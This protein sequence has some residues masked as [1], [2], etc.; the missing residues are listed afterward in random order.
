MVENMSG[1]VCPD[2]GKTYDIFGRGGA[3]AKA[4]ELDVSVSWANCRSTSRLRTAGDEGRLA[5][6]IDNDQR[7]RAPLEAVT[8][9]A[10]SDTRGPQAAASPPKAE[11]A[12]ALKH[13]DPPVLWRCHARMRVDSAHKKSH[14]AADALTWLVVKSGRLI[15]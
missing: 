15:G 8:R 9:R 13:S 10:G 14:V 12:D 11:F 5:E 7:A 1:F 3:R 2:C 6:V 4:E